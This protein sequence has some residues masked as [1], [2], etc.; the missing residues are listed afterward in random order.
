MSAVG[1]IVCGLESAVGLL[2]VDGVFRS[3]Y[4][5]VGLVSAGGLLIA[6]WCLRRFTDIVG[7]V[8]AGGLEPGTLGGFGRYQPGQ[9]I[10]TLVIP[11]G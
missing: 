11:G 9:G 1:L 5:I 2:Y 8:S 3:V 10:I 7:L 6:G 4:C